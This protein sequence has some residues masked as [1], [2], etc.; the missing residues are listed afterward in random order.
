LILSIIFLG[1]AV[2]KMTGGYGS[3]EVLYEIYFSGRDYWL[4]NFLRNQ[5]DEPTLRNIACYYSWLVAGTELL[6]AFLWL[7]PQR[8]ASWIAIAVLLNIALMSNTWLFSVLT[9]LMGLAVVG[10]HTPRRSESRLKS[11]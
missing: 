10:L 2:G 8:L 5:F 3:G 4:F 11:V 7:M 9:C 6:C 1:G